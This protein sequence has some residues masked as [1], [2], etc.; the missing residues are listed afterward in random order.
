M[1]YAP[2]GDTSFGIDAQALAILQL[3][4]Q[5][6]ASFAEWDEDLHDY[7]AM[8]RTFPWYK[9]REKGVAVTLQRLPS[10]NILVIAFGE[11]AASDSL[12]VQQWVTNNPGPPRA[13]DL[14]D[15][16]Q[17]GMT[18]RAEFEPYA[19][20]PVI[21]HIFIAMQKFYE[22]EGAPFTNIVLLPHDNLKG[23]GQK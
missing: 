14:E 21:E 7:K 16:V 20:G 15:R 18:H 8:F 23:F 11:L 1:T 6:E 19:F 17:R 12:F 4:A 13:E 5:R 3:L 9:G 22:G 10:Q 2:I